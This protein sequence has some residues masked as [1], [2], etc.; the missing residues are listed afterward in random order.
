MKDLLKF[1]GVQEVAEYT[2]LTIT[3]VKKLI[4]DGCIGVS[5]MSDN[6]I[7]VSSLHHYMSTGTRA[8]AAILYRKEQEE[9]EMLAYKAKVDRK[10]AI[11]KRL[12]WLKENTDLQGKELTQS[13]PAINRWRHAS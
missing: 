11:T 7:D 2:G 1:D 9:K 6:R 8:N 13:H 12:E 3:D 4:S 10:E 5:T